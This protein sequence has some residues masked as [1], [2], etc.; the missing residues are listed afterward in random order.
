MNNGKKEV[1]CFSMLVSV[2]HTALDALL[3]FLT[4]ESHGSAYDCYVNLLFLANRSAEW[5]L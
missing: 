2:F 5:E 4:Q 1:P 3:H